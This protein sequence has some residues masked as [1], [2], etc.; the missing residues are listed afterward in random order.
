VN[1]ARGKLVDV[2]AAFEALR[3]GRLA[4]LGLDVFPEEPAVLAPLVHPDVIV[5]PHAAGWHPGLGAKIAAGVAEA[6]RALLAGGE[7]PFLIA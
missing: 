3:T 6:L 5:T 7:V 4:G 1:T 2:A